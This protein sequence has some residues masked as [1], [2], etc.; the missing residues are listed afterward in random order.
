[1]FDRRE[2]AVTFLD[3]GKIPKLKINYVW[4]DR[5]LDKGQKDR[6]KRPSMNRYIVGFNLR[7]SSS[8]VVD[9]AFFI[10]KTWCSILT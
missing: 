3:D 4:R 7:S 8:D 6:L 1:M 10:L 9:C 5:S 2:T